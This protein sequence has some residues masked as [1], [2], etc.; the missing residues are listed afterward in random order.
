MTIV[1]IGWR[2]EFHSKLISAILPGKSQVVTTFVKNSSPKIIYSFIDA[3]WNEF[4]QDEFGE[5]FQ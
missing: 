5:T 3:A 1:I 4:L 2:A